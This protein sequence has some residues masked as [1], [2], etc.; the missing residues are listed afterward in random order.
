VEVEAVDGMT[1][2]IDCLGPKDI[3]SLVLIKNCSCGFDQRPILPLYNAILLM[4]VWCGEFMLDSFFI[5]K[6]FKIGVPKFRTIVTSYILDLQFIFI[7]I[8]SNE[9][10]DN[11]LSFTF[12]L[13]KEYPSEMRKIINN[14]KTIF[15]TANANVGN[16]SKQ[17]HV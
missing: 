10:L 13:Q 16:G 11:S 15:V 5:K 17:I 7:L 9:F 2:R 14:D 4:C 3:Q 8:S 1:R 6:F 12:I